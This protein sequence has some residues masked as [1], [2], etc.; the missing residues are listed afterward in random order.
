MDV[1]KS[2][3]VALAMHFSGLLF[4][5]PFGP[6]WLYLKNGRSEYKEFYV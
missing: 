6:L 5:F 2:R 1:G 4:L 3:A